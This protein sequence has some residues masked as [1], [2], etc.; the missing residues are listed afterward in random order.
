MA[1]IVRYNLRFN[2]AMKEDREIYEILRKAVENG[3]TIK[4]YITKAILHENGLE[5]EIYKQLLVH[6]NR[7]RML[8]KAV[9]GA[10]QT[11]E[12]TDDNSSLSGILDYIS[13][14]DTE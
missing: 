8:E 11:E 7:I 4:S 1:R 2:L 5:R 10:E 6:E 9:L 14:Y 12:T 13:G 3:T